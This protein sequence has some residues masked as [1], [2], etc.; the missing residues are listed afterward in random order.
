MRH[1]RTEERRLVEDLH[2]LLPEL[3]HE[4]EH[5]RVVLAVRQ[6]HEHLHHA[7]VRQNLLR[8]QQFLRDLA[9]HRDILDL[10]LLEEL[11]YLVELRDA[12]GLA[13][14]RAA[15]EL[16][17]ALR[18]EL[19]A[20][21]LIALG[22]RRLRDLDRQPADTGQQSDFFHLFPSAYLSRCGVPCR[23]RVPRRAGSAG[24][25]RSHRTSRP[26]AR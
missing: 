1:E 15:V 22:A 25:A 5:D 3:A 11:E 14:R 10:M 7:E 18:Q 9:D 8:E 4:R 2:A 20:A 26:P 13:H 12:D 19:H 23:C 6:G 24:N 21:D 17:V 16:L